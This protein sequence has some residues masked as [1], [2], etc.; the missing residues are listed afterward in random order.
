[1]LFGPQDSLAAYRTSLAL[2]PLALLP[3]KEKNVG[4]SSRFRLPSGLS[5]PSPSGDRML[6]KNVDFALARR[7]G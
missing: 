7:I 3:L 5:S 2:Y 4:C 6:R 1:M